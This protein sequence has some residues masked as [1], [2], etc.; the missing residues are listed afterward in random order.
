MKKKKPYII[1]ILI[2]IVLLSAVIILCEGY[3]VQIW[4]KSIT[5]QAKVYS[6]HY[7]LISEDAMTSF[8]QKVYESAKIEA[9]A[10]DIYLEL[11]GSNL[12]EEYGLEDYL[13]ISIDAKVDGIII[14][15]DGS[16]GVA[17]LINEAAD[18]GIPI[19]TVLEDEADT[20]RVSFVGINSYELGM[21][22][23][24][25]IL[26]QITKDTKNIYI[27]FHSAE[28]NSM[29]DVVFNQIKKTLNEAVAYPSI[30]IQPYYIANDNEFDSEEAIRDIFVASDIVPDVLVCMEEIDTECVC[31][32]LV[33]YNKVGAVKIIGSYS[34]E[35]ILEAI[36]KNLAAITVAMDTEQLGI[37]SVQ[38][39]NEY[40][41]MGYVSNYYNIDLHIINKRNVDSYLE[42]TA[43]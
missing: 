18:K 27:L 2:T 38:A 30:N 25:Q 3:K 40:Q 21:I 14:E 34:S 24:E 17:D 9:D 10:N 13:R 36:Q 33:D 7:V 15:P 8:W 29:N 1:G 31:Q 39:L 20:S 12:S 4:G 37:Q 5:S 19:V 42:G 6:K 41:E 26:G 35:T 23:G 32:A 11:A 16:Q 22:Y 43:N 28:S